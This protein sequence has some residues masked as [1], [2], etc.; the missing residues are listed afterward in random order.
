MAIYKLQKT[1][2]EEGDLRDAK[3]APIKFFPGAKNRIAC[4]QDEFGAKTGLTKEQEAYF[5]KELG[6]DPGTLARTNEK[7]WTEWNVKVGAGGVILNDEFPKHAMDIIVLKQR[8]HIGQT[9]ADSKRTG[10]QYIMTSEDHDAEVA[11][12]NRSYM[13]KAFAHLDTM[14][15]ED[16]SNYLLATGRKVKGLSPKA[17]KKLVGDDAELAPKNFLRVVQDDDKDLKVFINELLNYGI[18]SKSGSAWVD[19]QT[20]DTV[21]YSPEGMIQLFRDPQKQPYY[22]SLQKELKKRKSAK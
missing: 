10:I 17:I 5:E 14:T 8:S 21:E 2:H 13:V 7:F 16:M 11:N 22:V 18:F 1:R 9:L 20:G 15:E 6:L 12:D 3:G 4:G 19:E